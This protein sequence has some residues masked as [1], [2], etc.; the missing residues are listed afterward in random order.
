V[1]SR[2]RDLHD[3]ADGLLREQAVE[4]LKQR[5]LAGKHKY[6]IG[7]LLDSELNNHARS[8]IIMQELVDLLLNDSLEREA[9]ADNI[10]D[11]LIERY[12]NDPAQSLL[13]EEEAA[14]I[15]AEEMDLAR[16][17]RACGAV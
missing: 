4:S 6:G 5:I 17:A 11:G 3:A 15:E 9:L 12:L 10:R 2:N 7:E 8:H 1:G 14:E 13:I 16:I